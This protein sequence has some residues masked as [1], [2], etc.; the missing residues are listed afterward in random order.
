MTQ[1]GLHNTPGSSTCLG[2]LTHHGS[3][4]SSCR[5][6]TMWGCLQR[7]SGRS[8]KHRSL[9]RWINASTG[10]RRQKTSSAVVN[11]A[12]HREENKQ[13]LADTWITNVSFLFE[14]S[15]ASSNAT[16]ECHLSNTDVSSY[17]ILISGGSQEINMDSAFSEPGMSKGTATPRMQDVLSS[18]SWK[19]SMLMKKG[20]Q[21]KQPLPF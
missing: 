20:M 6:C 11:S 21:S 3:K 4:R 14:N 5:R 17:S 1:E 9:L 12:D 15:V 7:Q 10:A 13:H 16:D 8:Y 2:Q 18:R 19:C